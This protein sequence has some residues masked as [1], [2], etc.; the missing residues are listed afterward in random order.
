MSLIDFVTWR[1]KKW[2]K[3][4]KFHEKVDR[5]YTQGNRFV[6]T[7]QFKG[8][9]S[10]IYSFPFDYDL[11][12]EFRLVHNQKKDCH[13]DRI[14]FDLKGI[15][16][17]ALRKLYFHFL[18]QWMG[19]DRSDSFWTKWN[20]HLVQKPSPRSYPIHCERKWKYSFLSV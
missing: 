20:F 17:P 13:F 15:I 5:S 8:M 16:L 9:W 3:T 4:R 6:I 18:S 2:K 12:I 7:F 1:K 10:Y 14:P 19:Y 11:K